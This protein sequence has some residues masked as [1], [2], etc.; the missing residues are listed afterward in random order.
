MP[1]RKWFNSV[2]KII[3]IIFS[4]MFYFP[5]YFCAQ[6][7]R[8]LFSGKITNNFSLVL[9]LSQWFALNSCHLTK[10]FHTK[11]TGKIKV[12]RILNFSHLYT[13]HYQP[14]SHIPYLKTLVP[15][16]SDSDRSLLATVASLQ[17]TVQY[18]GSAT[19]SDDGTEWGKRD[20]ILIQVWWEVN[21]EKCRSPH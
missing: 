14:T 17:H 4:C 20:F 15:G 1:R 10:L 5:P 2:K 9:K 16:F 7:E 6:L 21:M 12:S 3:L 8:S 19:N 11:F 13:H 18:S